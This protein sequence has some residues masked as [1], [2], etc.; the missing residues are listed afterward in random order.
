[1]N[2]YSHSESWEMKGIMVANWDQEAN[3]ELQ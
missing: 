3:E 2:L 1:M